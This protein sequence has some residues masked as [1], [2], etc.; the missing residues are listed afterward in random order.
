M[1]RR[2]WRATPLPGNEAGRHRAYKPGQERGGR[3]KSPTES[4]AA[5]PAALLLLLMWCAATQA[6]LLRKRKVAL[7]LTFAAS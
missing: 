1:A 2:G 3:Q 7:Q 4:A 5:R 6:R